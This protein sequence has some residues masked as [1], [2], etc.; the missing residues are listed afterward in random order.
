MSLH[1]KEG[2]GRASGSTPTEKRETAEASA[3]DHFCQG[4]LMALYL[5]HRPPSKGLTHS[6]LSLVGTCKHLAADG[7]EDGS[8]WLSVGPEDE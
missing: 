1:Y 7:R 2:L 3:G 8:L 5:S 6:Y 4:P